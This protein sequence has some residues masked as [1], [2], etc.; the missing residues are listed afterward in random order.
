MW[1]LNTHSAEL[2]FFPGPGDVLGGYAIL[3]H[4][5]GDPE[6][7]DTFQKVRAAAEECKQNAEV[8]AWGDEDLPTFSNSPRDRTIASISAQVQD[9]TGQVRT[10][11]AQVQ[12]LT[13]QVRTHDVQVQVITAVLQQL[14]PTI[15][16]ST[17]QPGSTST[18]AQRRVPTVHSARTPV[19][20]SFSVPPMNARDCVSGKVRNF[21]ITAEEHGF[22]WA[23]ADTCCIDKT[24]SAELTEAINSMFLYYTHSDVCYVYLRDV[25]AGQSDMHVA[26]MQSQWHERGWTLQE[27]LAPKHVIFMDRYWKRLGTKYELAEIMDE[28]TEGRPPASVLRFEVDLSEMSIAARMSWASRRKTTR[29]EDQAY[30]LFGLFGINMPPLYGEGTNAFYRL[31]EEIMKTSPDTSLFAWSECPIDTGK[32][33]RRLALPAG[34]VDSETQSPSN[35]GCHL[36]APSPDHFIKSVIS[37]IILKGTTGSKKADINVRRFNCVWSSSTNL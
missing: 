30:C 31:Q 25:I 2:K 22:D 28:Y 7:E 3:S 27:L 23:W 5:W 12:D 15:P 9:L 13:V 10:H 24:S 32:Q 16:A 18:H 33:S 21:L 35:P 14:D 4:V 34:I 36:L 19:V 20:S 29:V 26:F 37:T 11:D 1:L 17:P 6:E 8:A